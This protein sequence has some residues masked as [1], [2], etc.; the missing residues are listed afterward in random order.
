MKTVSAADAN[1]QF[2][3]LLR[4]VKAGEIVVII[5]RGDP[6][7]QIVPVAAED[8]G[9]AGREQALAQLLA[10]LRSQRAL[11]LGKFSRDEL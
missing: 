2:S 11:D 4:E 1:R 8:A 5:S 6:V 3:K 7:P 9:A 10:R